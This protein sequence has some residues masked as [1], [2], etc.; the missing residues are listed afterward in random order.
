MTTFKPGTPPQKKSWKLLWLTTNVICCTR[1]QF[2]YV[3]CA[4]L[5]WDCEDQ[6][7]SNTLTQ[8][9]HV[10]PPPSPLF[11]SHLSVFGCFFL[12]CLLR[13]FFKIRCPVHTIRMVLRFSSLYLL[14]WTLLLQQIRWRSKTN[15]AGFFF[16]KDQKPVIYSV[17]Y[18]GEDARCLPTVCGVCAPAWVSGQS[19]RTQRMP[20][21]ALIH[22]I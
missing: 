22:T 10:I 14:A 7:W 6:R 3:V 20:H 2:H 18:G 13:H 11:P 21:V 15:R 16:L 1:L 5:R 19:G 17:S 9:W 12:H 8:L 4:M